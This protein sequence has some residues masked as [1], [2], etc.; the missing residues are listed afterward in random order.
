MEEL[1]ARGNLRYW[2]PARGRERTLSSLDVTKLI[3]SP[4][5][6]FGVHGAANQRSARMRNG[7]Y[8]NEPGTGNSGLPAAPVTPAKAG[9]SY[10]ASALAITGIPQL[11]LG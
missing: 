1:G 11:S 8:R 5:T 7:R 2:A 6:G 10:L 4:R 9:V 3:P